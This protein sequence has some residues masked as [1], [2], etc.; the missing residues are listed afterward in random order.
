MRGTKLTAQMTRLVFV[1]R[2]LGCGGAER[3]LV[4]LLKGIDKGKF[5]VS[6]VCL[7]PGGALWDEANCIPGIKVK[8]LDKKGRWDV[9]VIPALW[10]CMRQLKPDIVHGYMGVANTLALFGKLLRAKV[11]WGI[12][13]S[14][15]ELS[16][17]DFARRLV[18]WV[19][20]LLSPLPDLII[21]NSEAGRGEVVASGYP[22]ARTVSIANGIDVQRF[23]RDSV[24]REAVRAE[25]GIGREEFLI[26]LI[27]RLDPMKG[28]PVFMAAAQ[29][30][31]MRHP[32]ARF[33]VVGDG[34]EAQRRAL[35]D[36]ARKLRIDERVIW[37]GQRLDMPAVIS[38]L[39]LS[40]SASIG[41]GFS[42]ALGESMACG[43]PCVATDVGDSARIV[44]D[45]GWVVAPGDEVGLADQISKAMLFCR[46]P[47][48]H[49]EI[50][51]RRIVREF[52]I[53]RLVD[54]TTAALASL[55]NQ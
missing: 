52:S 26:G 51:R 6:L 22:V 55:A 49:P 41:E 42:N 21:C 9:R 10:S 12:R 46:T 29:R 36:L 37:A 23:R 47:E 4:E 54:A 16:H 44:G 28:H 43:V 8:S 50:F 39:D 24:G 3:Q 30:I 31:V 1:I 5:E 11:V 40:V 48:F 17:Y 38:A 53:E 34:P 7:Y 25:W 27:A 33:V 32:E 2:S 13:A 45:L 18:R 35:R 15:V 14:K 20:L 19:E